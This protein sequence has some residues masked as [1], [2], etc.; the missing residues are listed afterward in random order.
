MSN[1]PQKPIHKVAVI[2]AGHAGVEAA[3]WL[4]DEG[5]AVTLFSNE[6]VLP[7]FRPRLTSVAFGKE[8]PDAISIKKPIFYETKGIDLRLNTPADYAIDT[9]IVNGEAYDGLILATGASAHILPIPNAHVLWN[10]AD[11]IKLRAL[12]TSGK[13]IHIIGGGVLGIEAAVY[14]QLAGLHV[15]LYEIC[16]H[17]IS[18][19]LGDE[20]E[21]TLIRSLMRRGITLHIGS[22]LPD[23]ESDALILCAIGA[24]PKKPLHTESTLQV[25]PYVYT[26]GDVA[27]P[28]EQR[29]TCSVRK[30][31]EEA[32]LAVDNLLAE[33]AGEPLKEW[34]NP[35]FPLF[36]KADTVELHLYGKLTLPDLHETRLDDGSNDL[37][38]QAC[39]SHCNRPIAVR[40]VGT[41][42]KFTDYT[43]EIFKVIKQGE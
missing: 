29:P 8:E 27:A 34:Q 7:Y 3:S 2:G 20:G 36:M 28:T 25:A 12:C 4:A 10:M 16:P 6:S 24:S 15:S 22:P 43:T 9:R 11:A 30:A 40:M 21:A 35:I 41:R 13:V 5:C 38:Y 37:I 39:L 17:L 33:F 23:F 31:I 19:L 32:H 26:A 14:A 42:A 18:G 1:T